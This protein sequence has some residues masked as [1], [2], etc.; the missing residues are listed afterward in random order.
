M[1][2]TPRLDHPIVRLLEERHLKV[3]DLAQAIGVSERSIY[4]YMHGAFPLRQQARV[5]HFFRVLPDKVVPP[6]EVVS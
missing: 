5:A 1:S 2:R 4:L 3:H 6:K